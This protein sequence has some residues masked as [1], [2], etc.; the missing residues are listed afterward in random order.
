MGTAPARGDAVGGP[1]G[2]ID[3]DAAD[4][5]TLVVSGEVDISVTQDV[6]HDL[7]Q[8]GDVEQVDLTDTTFLDSSGMRLLVQVA[9]LVAPR[10]VRVVGA[11]GQPLHALEIF[12][13][14][15]VVDLVP[16]APARERPTGT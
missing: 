10:R 8:W 15:H 1:V 7:P 16:G 5:T 11:S 9:R 14:D 6:L 13:A 12:G 4:P 3:L 2:T